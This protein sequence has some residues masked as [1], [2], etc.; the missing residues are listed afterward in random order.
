MKKLVLLSGKGGTGKTTLAGAFAMLGKCKAVADCD[1]DA[2]NL[3]LILP[4]GGDEEKADFYGLE[5]AEIDTKKCT[6][7]GLCET[8]CRF[9][10]IEDGRIDIY[11]CEG[12]GVC[13]EFCPAGAITMTDY[14]AGKTK[15]YRSEDAVFSTA[16]LKMGSGNT[17]KLVT[18][19][20]KK[21]F[22]HAK[23]GA[24]AILD[25]SPGIGCPVIASITG[26]DMVLLVAEPTVS[27]MSDLARVVKSARILRARIGVCVN[28]WDINEEITEEIERYCRENEIDFL[29]RIPYDP[30][31]VRTQNAGRPIIK[32]GSPAQKAIL[33]VYEKTVRILYNQ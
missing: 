20:K 21:L 17:G 7:C 9:D 28:K 18:E 22:K 1:V 2:P 15:L 19:V 6:D 31:V 5:K 24:L 33:D 11:A 30:A 29:G 25:G 13:E 27:G 23:E 32:K 16:S 10:A 26:T 4:L 14:V 8:V 12:C 3:H